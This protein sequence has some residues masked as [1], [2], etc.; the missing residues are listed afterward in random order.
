MGSMAHYITSTNA[1][2]FQPMNANFGLFPDLPVK[3]KAKQER[4]EQHAKR[5]LE[6]IQNF[7]KNL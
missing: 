3:I 5:A 6:T 1:K 2:N 7:A 4:N